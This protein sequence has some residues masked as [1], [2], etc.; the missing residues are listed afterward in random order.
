[1]MNANNITIKKPTDAEKVELLK[2]P[3]WECGI[4]RFD[5]QYD[6]EEHCLITEGTARIEADGCAV[7]A[8][9]GDYVIFPKGLTCIWDV[10]QPIRKHYFFK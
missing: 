1:M 4:S 5:W 9:A 3:T 8:A 10:S 6:A 7:T 2:C